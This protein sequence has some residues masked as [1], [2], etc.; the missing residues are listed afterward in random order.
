MFETIVI[1][2]LM[3]IYY[4]IKGHSHA[5]TTQMD[6]ERAA[7]W[8]REFFSPEAVEERKQRMNEALYP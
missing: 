3:L 8:E 6:E 5:V 4:A 1:V 7:R 2:A